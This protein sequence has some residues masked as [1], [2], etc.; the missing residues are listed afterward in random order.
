MYILGVLSIQREQ[1]NKKS[2]GDVNK[3]KEKKKNR[4]TNK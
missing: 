1:K 4:Y 3:K 2:R